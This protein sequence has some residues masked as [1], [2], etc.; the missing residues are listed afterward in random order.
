IP[1]SGQACQDSFYNPVPC[2][3]RPIRL[4]RL[5]GCLQSD[6]L[7]QGQL[8]L[9]PVEFWCHGSPAHAAAALTLCA[10]LIASKCRRL[11]A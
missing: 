7:L 10:S 1:T 5:H 8:Q 9:P 4:S 3:L 6:G 11:A 2:S